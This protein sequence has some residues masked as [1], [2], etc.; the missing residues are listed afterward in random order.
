MNQKNW[1]C[2]ESWVWSCLKNLSF[3]NWFYIASQVSMEKV[4]KGCWLFEK[5]KDVCF[6]RNL[7]RYYWEKYKL[8]TYHRTL[9]SIIL[10]FLCTIIIYFLCAYVVIGMKLGLLKDMK[11]L[12]HL[13]FQLSCYESIWIYLMF[14]R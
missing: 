14:G 6:N 7:T 12:L 2:L 3:K 4:F 8:S 10:N 9:S 1:K 5:M 13:Y 11:A